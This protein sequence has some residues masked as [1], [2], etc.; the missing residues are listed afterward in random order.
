[1]DP[2]VISLSGGLTARWF[3]LGVVIG[4]GSCPHEAERTG[5]S[6]PASCSFGL[7]MWIALRLLGRSSLPFFGGLDGPNPQA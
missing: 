5:V 3:I 1:M 4:L 6:G 7:N 2:A